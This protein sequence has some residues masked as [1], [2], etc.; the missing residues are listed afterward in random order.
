[1]SNKKRHRRK[2][3]APSRMGSLASDILAGVIS[4]IATAAILKW[5]G[6]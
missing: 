5:L 3:M 6:W 4:G 2:P 1:M